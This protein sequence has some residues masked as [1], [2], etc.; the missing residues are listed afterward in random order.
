MKNMVTKCS[1]GIG[2]RTINACHMSLRER[3]CWF[4][5]NRAEHE[6]AH[7]MEHLFSKVLAM[8]FL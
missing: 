5:P 7:D 1:I 3:D 4:C 2:G 8:V 6:K